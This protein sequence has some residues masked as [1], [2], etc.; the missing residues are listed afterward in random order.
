M[1]VAPL[2]LGASLDVMVTL[3]S[4]GYA[5]PAGHTLR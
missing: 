5:M 1:Q 4:V 3:Q 2:E